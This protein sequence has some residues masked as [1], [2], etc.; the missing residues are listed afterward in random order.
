VGQFADGET[1]LAVEGK[2]AGGLTKGLTQALE[3]KEGFH[4]SF[5][6]A[7]TSAIGSSV[8]RFARREGLGLIA[9]S[10]DVR[11]LH[12]PLPRQPWKAQWQSIRSQLDV[13]GEVMGHNTFHYNLPTHYLVWAIALRR[14]H[15]HTPAELKDSITAYSMPKNWK[16][17]LPGAQKLGIVRIDGKEAR[18]TTTGE[19]V[20]DILDTTVEEWTDVHAAAVLRLLLMR[21]PMTRLVV[22]GLRKRHDGRAPLSQLA[23]ACSTLDYGRAMVLFFIPER[24]EPITDN[25]GRIEWD[26][27]RPEHYRPTTSYQYKSILKHAGIIEDTG[28][29]GSGVAPEDDVWVL[30]DAR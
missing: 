2:G 21:S 19:A 3:Y 25:R 11:V 27:L 24:L 5:L 22:A 6:A 4:L 13:A 16:P 30:R 18:L 26:R 15:W 9:V 17:A 20:Q 8:E 10:D 29:G 7:S 23:H 12:Y 1:L 14:G 28:L